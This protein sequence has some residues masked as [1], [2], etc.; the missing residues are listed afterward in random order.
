MKKGHQVVL[1]CYSCMR[2][3]R[4]SCRTWLTDCGRLRPGGGELSESVQQKVICTALSRLHVL[5]EKDGGKGGI[6]NTNEEENQ[7]DMLGSTDVRL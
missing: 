4:R 7:R 2:C 1:D 3:E 6:R 5:D